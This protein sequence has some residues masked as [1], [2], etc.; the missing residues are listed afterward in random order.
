[1]A[2]GEYFGKQKD[3]NFSLYKVLKSL[4]SG[5][6]TDHS[7]IEQNIKVLHQALLHGVGPHQFRQGLGV[8]QD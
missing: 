3:P 8:M 6:S 2:F 5:I 7:I 1:M 4:T